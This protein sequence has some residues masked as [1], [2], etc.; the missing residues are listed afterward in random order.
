MRALAA[1]L[2]LTLGVFVLSPEA[3]A[4][5]DS[6]PTPADEFGSADYVYLAQVVSARLDRPDPEDGFDGIEYEIEPMKVFKGAPP[7]SLVL[8]SENTSA[9][10]P[11]EVSGWYI[12][13]VGPER[14][15]G[16]RSPTRTA[17]YLSSCGNSF[18][19][20]ELPYALQAWPDDLTFDQI[21][22]AAPSR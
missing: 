20:N 11:M 4:H 2:A 6:Y 14:T 5:C 21:M 10:F 7:A 8:Y 1:T 16:F 9:R 12:V 17:R 15:V 13:F 19:L 3:S 18:A 22:S